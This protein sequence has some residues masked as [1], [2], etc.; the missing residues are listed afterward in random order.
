MRRLGFLKRINCDSVSAGQSCNITFFCRHAFVSSI[1]LIGK[2]PP[3]RLPHLIKVEKSNFYQTKT[4]FYAFERFFFKIPQTSKKCLLFEGKGKRKK[5]IFYTSYRKIY[6]K[7]HQTQQNV[8]EKI[9]KFW[10]EV[11]R[12]PLYPKFGYLDVFRA[13]L[14]KLWVTYSDINNLKSPKYIYIYII[15]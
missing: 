5:P 14:L 3:R 7:K 13:H 10:I 12:I 4:Y 2:Q 15:H 9:F 8:L 11:I 6:R 1:V